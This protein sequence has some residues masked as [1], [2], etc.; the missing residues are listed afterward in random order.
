MQSLSDGRARRA[1]RRNAAIELLLL[2]WAEAA[3]ARHLGVSREAVRKWK[4]RYRRA[5][6]AGLAPVP[7]PGRPPRLGA[8]DL[9]RLA[10]LL[11]LGARRHGFATDRWTAPRVAALVERELGV[12]YHPSSLRDLLARHGVDLR[13]PRATSPRARR[14]A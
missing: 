3:V 2:G 5:G 6:L 11:A 13:D 8:R 7:I 14:R 9:A 1:E 12:R 10:A 4:E